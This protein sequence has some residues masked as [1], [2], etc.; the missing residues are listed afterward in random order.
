MFAAL[1]NQL[2]NLKQHLQLERLPSMQNKWYFQE[3]SGGRRKNK[4]RKHHKSK[5]EHSMT[6]SA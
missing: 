3:L 2:S 4:A 6:C 5:P 1:E